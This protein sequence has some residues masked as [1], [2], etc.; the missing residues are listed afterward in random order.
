[1]DRWS[2]LSQRTELFI[3]L[4]QL[5]CL[6][7][8]GALLAARWERSDALLDGTFVVALGTFALAA[9]GI[10]LRTRRL[11]RLV[12]AGFAIAAT[13]LTLAELAGLLAPGSPLAASLHMVGGTEKAILVAALNT[14][15][16]L[17]AHAVHAAD[18]RAAEALERSVVAE[19]TF[20]ATLETSV[21]VR[22]A[23]L[24]DAQRVLQ[25]MWRLGQQISLELDPTR[26]LE[27][28][29]DAASDIAQADGAAIGL[30]GEDG[31]VRVPMARGA[32]VNLAG[33]QAPAGAC[34]MGRV[35]RAGTPFV[36]DDAVGSTVDLPFRRLASGTVRS[37]AVL[38]VSR[39]GERVGAVLLVRLERNPFTEVTLSRVNSMGDLLNVALEN[40]ELVETLRR[41][42]W[43]FRTLF[44]SAPDAV[45]TVL[46][47]G[48]IRE[49]NDAA[50]ELLGVEA[51]RMVGRRL[52][53]LVA[54]EDRDR[55]EEALAATF[56]GRSD[57]L[58]ITFCREGGQP[59]RLVSF[60][61]SLLPEADPPT[62]LVVARDVTAERDMRMRLMQ[63]DRLAAVG[64][65]VAGVAHE[66]NNP[67]SSISAYAQLL[68]RD[69]GLDSVLREQVEVIRSETTRASQV[70]KDLLAFARRSEPRHEPL[71]LNMVVARTLRMRAFQLSSGRIA[72]QQSL[73]D[74]LPPVIG[75]A[76]QLQQV[77]LNLVTNAAQA[78]APGAGGTLT[79]ST[80]TENGQ[81]VLEVADTG[82]GIPDELRNRVFEPFFTTKK[83]GEGTGLGLSVSY[84]IVTAHDGRIEIAHSSPRGTTFRVSLPAA[85]AAV[86][87]GAVAEPPLVLR[88]AIAGTRL[89]FVDDEPA[90]C[91]SV[92]AYARTRGF[93]VITAASGEAALEILR[94]TNVDA[95][96]CDI[97]MPGMDGLAFHNWL[98]LERPGL[99]TRTV[100]ITGDVVT[101]TNRRTMRQ[102]VL[103][104]PFTFE[105]LE[106]SVTAVIQGRPFTDARF[107]P[108]HGR[109]RIP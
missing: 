63:S 65:L 35:I 50:A 84:G 14:L 60:A 93:T 92:M 74:G 54:E 12:F 102:P 34:I 105:R 97:R 88:S 99:A 22:T 16:P 56:A 61:A 69:P 46:R 40:A 49:A 75:D 11:P 109:E 30:M 5:A 73:A 21:A 68:L 27:R 64:E 7:T 86:S 18:R 108:I 6:A 41:A 23:E 66:V 87:G 104:K 2:P 59:S 79:V 45:F 20:A 10:A 78:M 44:R 76:R 71:D 4:S 101:A 29:G 70:V 55:L 67:L 57:R 89:L 32:L 98:R 36:L 51:V 77:C 33:T 81:V 8:L 96:V 43:R 19:R 31:T 83:E 80:R 28:F 24:E 38:P 91:S 94:E 9:A 58:E 25:R 17:Y 82:S 52:G 85:E 15:L 47:S 42:E 107:T 26:V 53:E 3:A 1:M 62:V 37:V 95:V 39:R 72:V 90:I 48:R 13:L 100:F 106:A 103:A